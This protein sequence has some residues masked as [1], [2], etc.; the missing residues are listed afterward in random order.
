MKQY[1]VYLLKTN[2]VNQSNKKV[3]FFV[4]NVFLFIFGLYLLIIGI[5]DLKALIE[6]KV[7]LYIYG[8]SGSLDL[9]SVWISILTYLTIILTP[10]AGLGFIYSSLIGL[11]YKNYN[12]FR[13]KYILIISLL[14]SFIFCTSWLIPIAGYILCGKFE[15]CG[16]L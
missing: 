2:M 8:I 7:D 3:F 1:K 4:I 10:F 15:G 9:T 11:I 16:N 12:C 14:I 13:A 5:K 6:G